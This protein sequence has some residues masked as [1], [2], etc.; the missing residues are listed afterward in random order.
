MTPRQTAA[1]PRVVED[2]GKVAVERGPLV[3]CVERV[4]QT[5]DIPDL[6]FSA[7]SNS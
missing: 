7:A 1:N 5:A 6:T 3:Y 2:N 4:D